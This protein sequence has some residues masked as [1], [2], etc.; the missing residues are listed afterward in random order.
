[1]RRMSVGRRRCRRWRR[2]KWGEERKIKEGEMKEE[3][4]QKKREVEMRL[5]EHIILF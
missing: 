2:G 1:M 4:E 5:G 3:T